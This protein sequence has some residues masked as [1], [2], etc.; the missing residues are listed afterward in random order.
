[1]ICDTTEEYKEAMALRTKMQE[2]FQ[3]MTFYSPH[4][5]PI[6]PHPVAMWEAGFSSHKNRNRLGDVRDFIEKK[7]GNLSVLIH[8]HSLDGIYVDHTK[9]TFCAGKVLDLQLELWK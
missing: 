6:G 1:M 9:Y 7:H 4:D 8:P 2:N 5:I 3:W